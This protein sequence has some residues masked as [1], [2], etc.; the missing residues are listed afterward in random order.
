MSVLLCRLNKT[1]PN[2]AFKKKERGGINLTSVVSN[3]NF[4]VF[5]ITQWEIE[6]FNP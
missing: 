4:D 2:I 5:N 1:P 6:R 3:I